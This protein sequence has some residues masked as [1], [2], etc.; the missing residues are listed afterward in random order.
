MTVSGSL[1]MQVPRVVCGVHARAVRNCPW[2]GSLWVKH[3]LA[4]ERAGADEA[5]MGQVRERKD[6]WG[7]ACLRIGLLQEC[8][9]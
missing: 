2:V 4:Q 9:Q 8:I 3:L 6:L 5:T 1:A 7:R